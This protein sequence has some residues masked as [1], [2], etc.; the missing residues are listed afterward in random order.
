MTNTPLALVIRVAEYRKYLLCFLLL[1]TT[2]SSAFPLLSLFLSSQLHADDSTIGLY[3]VSTVAGAAVS[4]A[5]G[6][7]SDRIPSRKKLLRQTL[8]WLAFGWILQALTG[9]VWEAFVINVLFF[10]VLGTVSAQFFASLAETLDQNDSSSRSTITATIRSAYSLGYVVGPLIGTTVSSLYGL[11]VSFVITAALYVCCTALSLTL[12]DVRRELP[13]KPK[14]SIRSLRAGG[15]AVVV[16]IV[17]TTLVLSGDSL[18]SIYLPLYVTGHLGGSLLTF[19]TLMS[20]SA[21]CEVVVM[22]FVG[23]LSDHFGIYTIV[24]AGIAV[25]VVDFSILALSNQVWNLYL[26][27]VIHVI[28]LSVTLGLGPTF[29]QQFSTLGAGAASSIFFAGQ[30]LANIVAGTTG[31]I[32][33]RAIGLPGIFWVP[34]VSLLLVMVGLLL[35]REGGEPGPAQPR[36]S[37]ASDAE[38]SPR[39][40]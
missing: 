19:G 28:V 8:V 18:K 6:W 33:I 38:P 21:V 7:L 39:Q 3:A 20:V 17:G 27:Q 37:G 5:T 4:L 34:A 29:L 24:T 35:R 40:A 25:G 26:V 36:S 2:T 12:Q 13:Y 9:S 30:S 15:P 32:G 23:I 11:R 1:G 16:F 22:P 14:P 10:S 31:A